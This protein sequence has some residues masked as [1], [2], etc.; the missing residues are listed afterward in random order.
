MRI[1][2][3]RDSP[4][5]PAGRII[6]P[7]ALSSL[8]LGCA[9]DQPWGPSG[10]R[11]EAGGAELVA[12]Q[13][14]DQREEFLENGG[15]ETG[16]VWPDHWWFGHTGATDYH[17]AWSTDIA[18]TGSRSVVLSNDQADAEHFAYWAQ[19]VRVGDLSGTRLILAASVRLVDV[20]GEGI[21]LAIRGD[22]TA[23]PEGYAET[24]ATTEKA[25]SING[26]QDWT[27]FSVEL[28]E[29]SPSIQSIT[30]YLVYL[31]GTTGVVYIDDVS[32]SSGE[33]GT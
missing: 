15:V 18:H 16:E 27:T 32:L 5:R 28:D 2:S 33:P 17:F 9:V 11:Q 25:V 19:T 7:L 4:R 12:D 20:R 22:H 13:V 6:V 8:V 30:V 1:D 24:F 31:P 10:A 26:T 14:I 21:A 23:V 29:F 3:E